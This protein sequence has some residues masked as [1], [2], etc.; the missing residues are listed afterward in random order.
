MVTG[1]LAVP[2]VLMAPEEQAS[3]EPGGPVFDL[4]KK[5]NDRFRPR[6]HITSVII[7]DR[8]RDI[9][10]Q[11]P[12]WELYLNEEALRRSELGPLLYNGYDPDNER[13]IFGVFT[14]ADAV[15]GVLRLDPSVRATL[16]TAT[17]G[18]VKQAIHRILESPTGEPMRD[19]LSKDA[20]FELRLV[21]GREIKYWRAEALSAF[22]ASDNQKLGGG[23]LTISP[24]GDEVTLGKERFNRRVQEILR[25]DQ[26]SFRLWGIAIDINLESE[27]QGRTA[28]PFIAATVVLVLAVVGLTLRSVRVVGLTF[29]ALIMLL[30]WLRGGSNLLGLKSSL[31]LDLIVPIAMISLGVDF[32]IHAV[33][34]YQ[35]ERRRVHQPSLALVSGFAGVLGALTLAMLSDGVAF[36]AN[37]TSGIE[38]VIGFGIAAGVAV[39]ASYII[40]GMFLPLVIMRLDQRR[41]R[42]AT[43]AGDA[44]SNPGAPAGS[45]P[46][47]SSRYGLLARDIVRGLVVLFARHRWAVLPAVALLTVAATYLAFQLEPEMDVKEFFDADSDFVVSLDKLDQHTIPALSGEPAVLY[48]EGDLTALEPLAGIQALLDR[49]G[50]NEAVG[51]TEDGEV[52]L[53]LRTVLTLLS[54]ITT[55]EYASSRVL[56]GTGVAIT[57]A[58]GDRI[59]DTP[60]QVR[61]AYDYMVAAGIPLDADT[62][63]YDSDQV[64]ET[65]FHNPA[66]DQ[67]Q[68]TIIVLGILGTRQQAR[69]GVA[70]EALERDLAPLRELPTVSFAGLTG[71]PFTRESM[72]QATTRAMSTSLPLAVVACFVILVIWMR[73]FA[74]ALVTIIPVGLVVSW[75]YAFM[76]LAGFHLNFVTATVAAVS[77]GV[78]IDYSIHMTQRF[79]EEWRRDPDPVAALRAAAGGTGVAL[80]GSAASSVAGFAVMS[81][82]PMPMFSTYGIITATMILMAAGAALLVLPSLLLVVGRRKTSTGR[83]RPGRCQP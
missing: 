36:L 50:D 27:E 14:I 21:D 26:S 37:A 33:A 60:A 68:G 45:R 35:E 5:V 73:S 48:I 28:V 3:Q 42:I 66:T 79:R 40:M 29:L 83:L 76:Y 49:L 4:Q 24:A 77:I 22:V 63:V 17:D 46:N 10:R 54:R 31:T 30:V 32:V 56:A 8:E 15:Q 57:D 52:S 81:F 53:Y 34:R 23:P 78:G 69:V 55:N 58:D 64:R 12:L 47:P 71:S 51:Q 7:E 65:L 25:G 72:L 80:A 20:S 41:E 82:A 62:L 43:A 6:I 16:E 75:L 18:Q 19:F 59:P 39:F 11:E 13:Q 74:F 2:L 61:A 67:D 44:S 1:L 38:T 70:R 9:L